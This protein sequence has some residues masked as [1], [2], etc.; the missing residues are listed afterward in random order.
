LRGRLIRAA[1]SLLC[2]VILLRCSPRSSHLR[3]PNFSPGEKKATHSLPVRRLA[4]E[5]IL[6]WRKYAYLVG[7]TEEQVADILGEPRERARWQDGVNLVFQHIKTDN[8]LITLRV[9]NS[10]VT[11]VLIYPKPDE[12]FDISELVASADQFAFTSGIGEGSTKPFL[13]ATKNNLTIRIGTTGDDGFVHTTL[14]S[15][16]LH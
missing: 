7:M 11:F 10:K 3:A 8:R 1:T 16:L 2:G 5:E 15:V 13:A 9:V 14:S 12:V 4:L 6:S